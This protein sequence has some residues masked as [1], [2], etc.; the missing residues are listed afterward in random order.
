MTRV[1]LVHGAATSARVWDRLVPLLPDHDVVAVTRPR[2][3]DL[4]R[5][6]AWL[7][8]H[9]EGAWVVGMSGGAT[10]GLALASA[11]VPLAGAVLHEPAVGSLAPGLLAPMVSAFEEGG[12]A[13]FARTLYGD[14]WT[15]A[16]AGASVDDD[17]TALELAMF[18]AFEPEPPSTSS[19]RVV[20]TVGE[21]SPAVRHA[22]VEALRASYCHEVLIVP[23]AAHFAAYET[24]VQFASTVLAVIEATE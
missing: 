1:V 13:A 23:G 5:E 6:L 7:A 19:G 17:V 2:T 21:H 10:L 8:P 15:P 24:P 14:A 11:H 4:T 22:S 18:R 3:G 9:V 20:V 16:L 12:T